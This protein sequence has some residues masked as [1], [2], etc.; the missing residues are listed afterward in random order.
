MTQE[1]HE[2][3]GLPEGAEVKWANI[4]TAEYGH[5]LGEDMVY[6]EM[7][8][9]IAIDAGSYGWPDK[10]LRVDAV[11]VRYGW[12]C[13]ETVWC[14]DT[15]E[16]AVE[17]VRMANKWNDT[18][19]REMAFKLAHERHKKVMRKESKKAYF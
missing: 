16:M 10:F 4:P 3:N 17:V 12:H 15:A 2:I 8:G 9:E 5:Y 14:R 18:K 13:V 11:H 6:I 19:L 1:Y 7:G